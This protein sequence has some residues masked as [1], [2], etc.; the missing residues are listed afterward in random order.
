MDRVDETH[1]EPALPTHAYL[2]AVQ[3]LCADG[4]IEAWH[5][6]PNHELPAFT[7]PRGACVSL[8]P[9][10][11]VF[12]DLF[13]TDLF[14]GTSI[15]EVKHFEPAAW[16]AAR[17]KSALLSL[18][19]GLVEDSPSPPT[20]ATYAAS[21]NWVESLGRRGASVGLYQ[22]RRGSTNDRWFVVCTA[23]LD[24]ATATELEAHL[25]DL[26]AAGTPAG[27]VFDS[28]PVVRRARN[29]AKRNRKRLIARFAQTLGLDVVCRADA[30]EPYATSTSVDVAGLEP[31]L[32]YAASQG[33]TRIPTW[34]RLPA[35]QGSYALGA[36]LPAALQ[37][38]NPSTAMAALRRRGMR[39]N[40][41]A[42]ACSSLDLETE[43]CFV[44]RGRGQ[45]LLFYNEAVST[46]S[47]AVVVRREPRD[48]PL[49]LS[50]PQA[51][52]RG[53]RGW[54]SG[55]TNDVFSAFP[56]TLP[57]AEVDWQNDVVVADADKLRFVSSVALER[58]RALRADPPKRT[59]R[60]RAVEKQLGFRGDA[61]SLVPFLVRLS[62]H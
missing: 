58:C 39:V 44:E 60:W 40:E 59:V 2:D 26:E 34:Y 57:L 27:R 28:D 15:K 37:G 48:G 22:E 19:A 14:A 33:L 11:P 56:S 38:D 29:V 49:I 45:E 7:A 8:S 6:L 61:L 1:A 55:W 13:C 32:A 42:F 9:D 50:V 3:R 43:H 5:V 54:G 4:R 17:R 62:A 18:R 30:Q 23:S 24:H 53:T 47:G 36:A 46:R 41:R 52:A 12:A 51:S 10:A 35:D 25:D 16:N 20:L 31:A 21:E